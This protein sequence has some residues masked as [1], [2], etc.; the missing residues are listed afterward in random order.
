MQTQFFLMF[1]I[2]EIDKTMKINMTKIGIIIKKF[3][4]KV[5]K[6]GLGAQMSV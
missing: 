6:C 4:L 3:A 1:V 2:I 5:Y